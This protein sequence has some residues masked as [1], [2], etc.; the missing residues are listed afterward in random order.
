LEFS[1]EALA[2]AKDKILQRDVIVELDF[3][4][5]RGSFFGSLLYKGKKDFALELV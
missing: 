3:A 5:K 1:N 4:D 2:F